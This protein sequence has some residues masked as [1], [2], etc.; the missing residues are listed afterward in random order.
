MA[1]ALIKDGAVAEYPYSLRQ[2]RQANPQTSFPRGAALPLVGQNGTLVEVTEGDRPEATAAQIA[3][4]EATPA[5]EN[6]KWVRGWTVRDKTADEIAADRENMRIP[7]GDFAVAAAKAGIVT[8]AEAINWAGGTSL[9]AGIE[10]AFSGL[11]VGDQLAARVEALTVSHIR[12]TAPLILMLQGALSLTD[13][14]V[15]A[16][17]NG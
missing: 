13:A 17:F 4:P 9:P 5:L 12:R 7:R 1:Y 11:P 6:G 10:S 16:L 2:F 15:D 14:Q 8:D 3:V